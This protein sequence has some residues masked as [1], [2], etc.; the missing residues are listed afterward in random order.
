LPVGSGIFYA[1]GFAA[2]FS[3][4][5]AARSAVRC[6]TVASRDAIRGSQ[7]PMPP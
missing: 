7:L 3:C 4:L 6:R 1:G 5:V 2:S